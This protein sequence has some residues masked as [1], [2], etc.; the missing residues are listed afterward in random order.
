[1]Q[2]GQLRCKQGDLE[3]AIADYTEAIA[4]E[5]SLAAYTGRAIVY[6]SA[7]DPENAIADATRA[8]ALQ[9]DSALA[10]RLQ[11]KGFALA[12][13]SDRAVK[14][15]KQAMRCYLANNDKESAR[16]CLQQ[17]ERLLPAPTSAV[18]A[19]TE[20]DF[21]ARARTQ[22]ERQRYREA[23]AELDWLLQ[24]APDDVR[25]LCLRG[26]ARARLGNHPA[27]EQDF[28]RAI[29]LAP[30]DLEIRLQ[31]GM[32]LVDLGKAA[33]AEIELTPL[34]NR[35]IVRAIVYRARAYTQLGEL[36]IAEAEYGRALELQADDPEIYVGRSQLREATGDLVEAIADCQEAARL[37]RQSGDLRSQRQYLARLEALQA[38]Q[39]RETATKVCVPIKYRISGCAVIDVR[40]NDRY[41]FEML[42]DTGAGVTLVTG[43]MARQ[44]GLIP[45]RRAIVGVADG[46][47]V[48]VP[49]AVVRSLAVGTFVAGHLE[50]AIADRMAY[51]LLGQDFFGDYDI[52]LLASEVEFARRE[53]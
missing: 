21:L 23:N 42:L 18:S 16:E 36:L 9:N 7:G 28:H 52:R 5:P 34:A 39:K 31:W 46:R 43:D 51:G 17:I 14:A 25:A 47:R 49:L 4:L 48:E 33:A 32:L 40:F 53:S 50:V 8:I 38:G 41:E 10:H 22:I 30:N 27:A 12:G 13:E 37:S 35:R 11:G 24:V 44:L 6:L 19:R 29:A 20:T 2:R 1:M 15:Y 45:Q 26:T 3:R